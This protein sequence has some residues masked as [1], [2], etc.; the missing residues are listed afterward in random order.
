MSIVNKKILSLLIT[1]TLSLGCMAQKIAVEG[2]IT[3]SNLQ[4]SLILISPLNS[5]ARDTLHLQLTD[6]EKKQY[7][8]KGKVQQS[9]DSLYQLIGILGGRQLLQPIHIKPGEALNMAVEEGQLQ[10]YSSADNCALSAFNKL[11]MDISRKLWEEGEQM[12]EESIEQLLGRYSQGAKTI[13]ESFACSSTVKR[14]LLLWAYT[15]MKG[16]FNNLSF[17]TK[18]NNIHQKILASSKVLWPDGMGDNPQKILDCPMA[19]YFYQTSQ[20]IHEGLSGTTVAEKM[21]SL[22]ND[23]HCQPIRAKV[24]E[25]LM[26]NYISHFNYA[27]HFEE[28]LEEIKKITEQYQLDQKFLQQFMMRRYSTKHSPFPKEVVLVDSTGK[29]VD[30]S[31][32]H[33]KIVYI[34]LWASWCKPCIKEIP[35]LQ[36]LEKDLSGHHDIVFVSISIDQNKMAW[37]K[38]MRELNLHGYQLLDEKGGLSKY[39]NINSIPH[40]LIYDKKGRL[41]QY[42][43]SRPSSAETLTTLLKLIEK[44]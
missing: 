10:C 25:L 23:Y 33:N 12:D 35:H 44:E 37:K 11:H 42:K 14:Y 4:S 20:I 3:G 18:K 31:I 40:F 13:C 24:S 43:A 36:Q 1:S 29:K 9:A 15:A 21:Y 32:F 16:Q 30:F 19:I 26:E 8:L 5:D 22:Y 6:A 41:L 7:Q 38:K 28:G 17:I 39:L 27:S 2:I 34:D